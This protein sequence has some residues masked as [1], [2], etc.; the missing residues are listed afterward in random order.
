M[1][2]P[3]RHSVVSNDVT[4]ALGEAIE[5]ELRQRL[6]SKLKSSTGDELSKM[7]VHELLVIHGN[8]K[9]RLPPP[10][11]R[12]VHKASEFAATVPAADES[13]VDELVE[14]IERGDDL[15]PHLS[16]LVESQYVPVAD[17]KRGPRRDLDLMLSTWGVHHFHLSKAPGPRQFNERTG[18]LLF[19][20]VRP[21]DAYLIGIYNHKSWPDQ[22]IVRIL[23]RNWPNEGLVLGLVGQPAT[24]LTDKD[25]ESTRKAGVN[26]AV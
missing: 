23:W 14:S 25:V 7:P 21:D 5:Q 24:Q 22:D 13:D 3:I 19:G 16:T 12:V 20:V 10:R 6:L 8:W 2:V 9:Y 15:T 26:T 1:A 11:P 17:R 18:D 4:F